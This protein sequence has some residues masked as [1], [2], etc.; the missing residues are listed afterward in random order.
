MLQTEERQSVEFV[1]ERER[2]LDTSLSRKEPAR[3][4]QY[5]QTPNPTELMRCLGVNFFL[6]LYVHTD[7]CSQLARRESDT[8][9]FPLATYLMTSA[10]NFNVTCSSNSEE[11]SL[12]MVEFVVIIDIRL[13]QV[14]LKKRLRD[15]SF[16]K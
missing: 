11:L 9:S 15:Q 13:A 8:K 12:C 5:Y 10:S 2:Q 14:F 3:G 6:P 4:F 16:R 1:A 7:M